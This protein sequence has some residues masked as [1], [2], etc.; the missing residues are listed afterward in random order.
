MYQKE[1]RKVQILLGIGVA[2]SLFVFFGASASIEGNI[3]EGIIEVFRQGDFY[4][5]LITLFYPL[6]L[7]Y[8][9]RRMLGLA[10]EKEP[11][12][13]ADRYYTVSERNTYHSMQ[14]SGRIM[15]FALVMTIGWIPGVFRAFKKLHYLKK[16]QLI[17]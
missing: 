11:H 13:P 5:F 10:T 4:V 15:R 12:T 1:L 3:F 17:Q 16:N 2:F 14:L 9:W 7:F 8:N 6:G